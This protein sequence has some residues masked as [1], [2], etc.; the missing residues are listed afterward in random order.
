MISAAYL[1]TLAIISFII[2]TLILINFIIKIF[3]FKFYGSTT[4]PLVLVFVLCYL[5]ALVPNL[6]P[7]TFVDG[8]PQFGS[9]NVL[10]SM[11]TSIFD[12][13]KM[14]AVSFEKDAIL[15]Y[16]NAG[17][18]YKLFS[19]G[20]VFTS[21][22]ALLFASISIIVFTMKT[23]GAK[24]KTLWFLMV[25]KRDI[26]YIFSDPKVPIA[27]TL[28]QDLLDKKK[29][30]VM[31]ITRSSQKTQEGTEYK[32]SLLMKG[33]DVHI[34]NFS[35]GICRVIFSRFGR[36]RR[37]FV[38]GIFSNDDLSI[39]LAN[40]FQDTIEKIKDR[41]TSRLYKIEKKPD[42][43][44]KS[45]E[46]L[47]KRI[48]TIK[49]TLENTSNDKRRSKKLNKKLLKT[50]SKLEKKNK[51]LLSSKKEMLTAYRNFK[52]FV[53][54]HEADIDLN[55]NYSKKTKHIINTLSEYDIISTDF[56]LNNPIDSFIDIDHLD[57]ISEGSMN[58][59]FLGFGKINRPI[60][61][62]MT[63]AYQL[64]GDNTHKI[65][66]SILD[67]DS[68]QL[69]EFCNNEYTS[70]NNK[71]PE[72]PFLYKVQADCNQE[73]LT[74]F[75]TI[76]K[77][78]ERISKDESRFTNTGFEHFIVS[79]CD[80]NRDIKIATYL[81]KAIFKYVS[82][83]LTRCRIY[84]RISNNTLANNFINNNDGLPIFTLTKYNEKYFYKKEDDLP[85]VPIIVFGESALMSDYI[86]NRY[87][88]LYK[89]AIGTQKSY[90]KSTG[91]EELD[92][93]NAE[94]DIIESNK[95]EFLQ[96]TDAAYNMHIKTKLLGYDLD[97]NFDIFENSQKISNIDD[98]F[99][100]K[101]DNYKFQ[102]EKAN[103][104]D[105]V[106]KL[107]QLEHNRWVA[108][109]YVLNKFSKWDKQ[110]FIKANQTLATNYKENKDNSIKINQGLAQKKEPER[111]I[112]NKGFKT[113]S[114]DAVHICMLTNSGL[115]NLKQFI[116]QQKFNNVTEESIKKQSYKLIFTNDIN[117]IKEMLKA[118]IKEF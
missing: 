47:N 29:I 75:N 17:G 105:D 65:T 7:I 115:Y 79:V 26:C 16:F 113:S 58:V 22:S 45:I 59:S 19:I 13:L 21:I 35:T 81:R 6:Y 87:D 117:Q 70:K 37:T 83:N 39:S 54:Y 62:K 4:I 2:C 94:L 30:V 43:I 93:V 89:L 64:W 77:Y 112:A 116:D 108:A 114:N 102:V 23:F 53:T 103:N 60:F 84:V 34:E 100:A 28:G 57:D 12:A 101:I 41:K 5:F 72:I 88:K 24:I 118:L 98:S 55:N 46:S 44:T 85:E 110:E 107:A 31:V 50:S 36:K 27:S 111:D 32:D 69:A 1:S 106:I 8:Q 96:N 10:V 15:N 61:E 82:N 109:S 33:F 66:Y 14:F 73:D 68:K 49:E 11:A 42:E 52:V 74:E 86:A 40:A 104:K 18:Y 9:N 91:D 3:G 92:Y 90:N 71:D 48:N 51:E 95:K 20:Y 25:S 76:E 38:Y 63:G 99:F 80:T 78:V 67:R 97:H 56:V